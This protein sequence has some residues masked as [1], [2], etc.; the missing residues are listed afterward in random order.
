M[1]AE[2]A[3]R[4]VRSNVWSHELLYGTSWG[5]PQLL[6]LLGGVL[7]LVALSGCLLPTLRAMRVDPA[8]ALRDE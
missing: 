1:L 6:G 7:S 2:A 8:R 4:A 5:D 3:L